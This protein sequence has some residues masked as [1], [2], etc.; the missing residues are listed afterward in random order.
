MTEQ[1]FEPV[2]AIQC[3]RIVH[4]TM[5]RL[6][7]SFGMNSEK[8][9]DLVARHHNNWSEPRQ[10]DVP[11]LRTTVDRFDE[12]QTYSPD[13]LVEFYLSAFYLES[14]WTLKYVLDG[15][16]IIHITDRLMFMTGEKVHP[17]L[18]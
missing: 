18:Q 14:H 13:E 12:T 2:Q 4:L 7:N 9:M 10:K 15:Q 3:W 6:E 17:P 5:V 1:Q 8:R 11:I 16:D